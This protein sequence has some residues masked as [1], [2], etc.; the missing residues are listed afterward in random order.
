MPAERY[1]IET[2]LLSDD[3]ISIEGVE[4]HHLT[5]VMRSKVGESLE[6]I[7]GKGT[8]AFAVIKQLEKKK[9]IV[10]INKTI[11]V[12]KQEHQI[13]LL[14]ALPRLNRLDFIVEKGTELGM[15]ELWL[16]PGERSERKELSKSQLERVQ[17][18]TIAA[19]KQCGRLHLPKIIIQPALSKWTA[20]DYPL[21]FGD[22]NEKAPLLIDEMA[23]NSEQHIA[24]CT[25]P[26]AGFGI[27]EIQLLEKLGAKGVKLHSNI[28]RTDTASIMALSLISHSSSV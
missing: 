27:N 6:I 25:G 21:Y 2:D 5:N 8:L 20:F 28:L 7:N 4:F 13:I 22:L 12:P 1:Y 23:K 26:E 11:H 14:Q 9:A 18:L 24:F 10:V 3:I 16:F 17:S 19:S 15:T